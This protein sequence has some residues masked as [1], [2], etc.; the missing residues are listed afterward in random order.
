MMWSDEQTLVIALVAGNA[1][2]ALTVDQLH[3]WWSSHS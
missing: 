2:R 1:T 3:T